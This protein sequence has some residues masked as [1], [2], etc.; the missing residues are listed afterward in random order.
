MPER[1]KVVCIPCSVLYKCSV[2]LFTR[3]KITDYSEKRTLTYTTIKLALLSDFLH[4]RNHYL[5]VDFLNKM[6]KFLSLA[7]CT[8]HSS[9]ALRF[10]G[11]QQDTG[12]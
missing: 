8:L 6:Q 3:I 10:H 5:N 11:L 2:L 7:T 4:F 1:F 12:A 9:S